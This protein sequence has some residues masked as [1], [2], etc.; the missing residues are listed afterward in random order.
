MNVPTKLSGFDNAYESKT[1]LTSNS[2]ITDPNVPDPEHLPVPLG[3]HILIRPYPVAESERL[4]ASGLIVGG[5]EIDF[6]NYLTNI[7]RVV[8]IGP[9]CWNRAEHKVNGERHEWVK[10]GDFVSFPKNVGAKRKFK[11][12]SFVILQDDEIV[13]RLPDPR[14]FNDSFYQINVPEEHMLKYNTYKKDAK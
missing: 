2:W 8:A 13:E 3:W 6:L 7:G 11:N 9:A 10:V 12:V 14:V 5:G 4:T 1:K